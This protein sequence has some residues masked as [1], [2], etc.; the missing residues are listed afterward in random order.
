MNANPNSHRRAVVAVLATGLLTSGCTSEA[1]SLDWG[2]CENGQLAELYTDPEYDFQ[3][4]SGDFECGIL[5]VPLDYDDPDGEQIDMAVGRLSAASPEDRIGTLFVNP[6]GPGGSGVRFAAESGVRYPEIAERF[7]VVGFDPRGTWFST[8]FDCFGSDDSGSE[9]PDGPI[10]ETVGDDVVNEVSFGDADSR[11]DDQAYAD[12]CAENGGPMIDHMSTANVARDMD[13][14]RNT[15]DLAQVSYYGGSYGSLLGATYANLFPDTIRAMAL[16]SAA[17]PAA[18]FGTE[19]TS[20]QPL[21]ARS[22]RAAAQQTAL[23]EFFRQCDDAPDGCVLAPDSE[24]RFDALLAQASTD[25]GLTFPNGDPFDIGEPGPIGR[26]EFL[27]RTVYSTQ[28]TFQWRGFTEELAAAEQG[29]LSYDV[30][31]NSVTDPRSE[32]N[33][34]YAE[35]YSGVVCGETE[36]PTDW[37]TLS[38]HALEEE[39]ENGYFGTFWSWAE[40]PCAVWPG[41]DEDRYAGP[42]DTPTPITIL[43]VNNLYDPALGIEGARALDDALAN[44]VLV[45]VEA[46]G[47]VAHPVSDCA[48]DTITNYLIT[49]EAPPQGTTCVSE[50]NPFLDEDDP[51]DHLVVDLDGDGEG[52]YLRHREYECLVDRDFDESSGPTAEDER[53][54]FD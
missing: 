37:D 14:L 18:W 11:T 22:D 1:A 41:R 34:E 8:P 49:A 17:N 2:E 3:W 16:D 39:A 19:A 40:S 35:G 31:Y 47:H 4:R 52:E 15:L 27:I 5:E 46:W 32:P 51:D 36:G 28:F 13:R 24:T 12:A 48:Y 42:W 25:E 30:S 23:D 54:C 26:Q 38:D 29:D 33:A 20:D 10:E 44:S 53:A 43:I 50:G 45:E 9:F 6:G 21:W 7:D